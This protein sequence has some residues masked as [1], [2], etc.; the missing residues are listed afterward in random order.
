MKKSI[1][2]LV[3]V[4]Y[5]AA[6][7]SCQ[8]TKL[9]DASFEADAINSPPNKTLPGSPT[10]DEIIYNDVIIPQLKVV[11]STIAG[12]KALA[13]SNVSIGDPSELQRFL[14]FK[15]GP[16]DLTKTV[17]FYFAGQ[18]TNPSED[19][20]IDLND[21]YDASIARMRIQP[22]G[23]VS[24][25]N[26]SNYLNYKVIGNVG[27]QVHTV[28]FTTSLVSKTY[29]LTIFRQN[30]SALTAENL[31]FI[32]QDATQFKNP[33]RPTIAFT[34]QGSAASHTYALG[35]VSISKKKPANIP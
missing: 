5:F 15:A 25:V 27:S 14:R 7:T 10:G 21:G 8:T 13:F 23:T 24:V 2:T 3:V 20:F 19:V 6:M 31:P 33:A 32:E 1:Y 11:S 28:I 29:N 9:L 12:A 17:W 26:G 35:F 4:A 34:H 30:Q 16:T 22:D 18:N